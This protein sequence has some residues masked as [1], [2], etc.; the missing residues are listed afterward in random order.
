MKFVR[1]SLRLLV[2][3]AAL[4]AVAG[5]IALVKKRSSTPVTTE[6]WPDVPTRQ[7]A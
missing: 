4:A 1:V 3:I 6:S 7:V 2:I 5:I